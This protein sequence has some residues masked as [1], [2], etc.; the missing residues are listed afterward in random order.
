MFKTIYL[1]V[2][3]TRISNVNF[4]HNL[5]QCQLKS[6]CQLNQNIKCLT[7]FISVSTQPEYQMFKTIYLSVNSTRI[8]NV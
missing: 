5:S 2:N 6:Q 8:S 3:S 1:S 4:K 7:Q